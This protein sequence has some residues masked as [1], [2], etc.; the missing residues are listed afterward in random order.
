[1]AVCATTAFAP[2][3]KNISNDVITITHKL[4]FILP[5]I[6]IISI[7]HTFLAILNKI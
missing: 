2:K 5:P 3:N 6:N 1:M 4:D 7:I